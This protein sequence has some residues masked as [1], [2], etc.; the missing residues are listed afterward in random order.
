MS[1]LSLLIAP[2]LQ[3]SSVAELKSISLKITLNYFKQTDGL[4]SLA[5]MDLYAVSQSATAE[6]G[7]LP[8]SGRHRSL[9]PPLHAA[10]SDWRR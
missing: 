7:D 4:L 9:D 2:N 10:V 5:S 6:T 8:E 3:K 1:D